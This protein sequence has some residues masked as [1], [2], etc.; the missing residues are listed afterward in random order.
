MQEVTAE[1]NLT[2]RGGSLFNNYGGLQKLFLNNSVELLNSVAK[3]ENL[4][5]HLRHFEENILIE[6]LSNLEFII[7]SQNKWLKLFESF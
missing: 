6:V 7:K 1:E 2:V 5:L 3:L 4:F